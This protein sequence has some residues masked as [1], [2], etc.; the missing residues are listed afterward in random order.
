VVRGDGLRASAGVQ[1]QPWKPFAVQDGPAIISEYDS[2]T[3]VLPG[4]QWHMDE[5][6]SIVIE[7][8]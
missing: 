5:F 8:K 3:V 4:Q 7:E 2:T 1:H 6:G